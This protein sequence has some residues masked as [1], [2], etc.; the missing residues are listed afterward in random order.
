MAGIRHHDLHRDVRAGRAD[1]RGQP[2]PGLPRRGRPG[3]GP[4]GRAAAIR[5]GHNQ[6]APLPGVPAL[7][8]AIADA[9]AALLRPRARPGHR[10]RRSRSAPPRR[11]PPRCS[12]CA[13]PATRWSCFEPV[14]R[15][16]RGGDRDGRRAAASAGDAAPAGLRRSTRTRCAAAVTP[17]TRAAAAQHAAQPDRQGARPR[18]AGADRRRVRRARPDRDHRRG[19]RA[20]GLRRRARPAGHAAR[21]GRADADDLLG[22]ARRSPSR[23]G[24]SAGRAGRAPLVA[25]GARGQ[26]VPDLRRRRRRSSTPVARRAGAGRRRTTRRSRADLR[27]KR[28]L[29]CAR[30]RGGRASRCCAPAGHVLRHRRRAPARHD[31]GA[32]FC[33]ELPR[34]RAASSPS[35]RASS[36]TTRRAGGTSCGSRS[37]SATRSST[38]RRGGWARPAERRP[39]Y[40]STSTVVS[41]RCGPRSKASS[42]ARSAPS[43]SVAA[44]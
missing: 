7:R 31:D 3:R 28:D 34:A 20:P 33:R 16:L 2:R 44:R 19:L 13:S 39:R 5:D 37:A 17:R 11:S 12:P 24:R 10:G 27:A 23:A 18:R 1:R 36:T 29:L 35:R 40:S 32:A 26:A 43:R 30:A 21:H 8:E 15:L 38:R 6:Y 14:L 4:R 22:S 9:P 42:S 41:S 25:R